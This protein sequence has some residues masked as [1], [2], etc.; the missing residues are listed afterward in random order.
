MTAMA[1][2]RLTAR[3]RTVA[4]TVVGLVGGAGDVPGAVTGAGVAVGVGDRAETVTEGYTQSASERTCM[5]EVQ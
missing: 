5:H 1:I 2:I 3:G 4:G